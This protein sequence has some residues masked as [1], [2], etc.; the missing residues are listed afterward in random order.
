MP[1]SSAGYSRLGK[2]QSAWG[3]KMTHSFSNTHLSTFYSGHY[4]Y[5]IRYASYASHRLKAVFYLR[6]VR[7]LLPDFNWLCAHI[8]E[9]RTRSQ[10][11]DSSKLTGINLLL[12]WSLFPEGLGYHHRDE[13]GVKTYWDRLILPPLN[14]LFI[15]PS[16]Q[17]SI[18]SL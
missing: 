18:K 1:G 3:E 16:F 8:S 15:F 7:I 4:Q 2:N 12:C 17:V 10:K 11:A 14:S 9:D 5:K 6:T 13:Q